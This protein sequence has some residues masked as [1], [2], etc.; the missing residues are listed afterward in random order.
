MLFRGVREGERYLK[1]AK[2]LMLPTGVAETAC[3]AGCTIAFED[4]ERKLYGIQLEL[5]RNDPEGTTILMN[6]SCDICGCTAWWTTNAARE[7]AEAVLAKAAAEGP[8]SAME[9][10]S[11]SPAKAMRRWRKASGAAESPEKVV[12]AVRRDP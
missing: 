3:A 7:Q 4:A 2:T 8:A 10:A 6:F 5:E 12:T 1:E 11:G 9:S